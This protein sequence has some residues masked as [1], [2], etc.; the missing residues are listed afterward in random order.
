M[1]NN[2]SEKEYVNFFGQNEEDMIK[3]IKKV[4]VNVKDRLHLLEV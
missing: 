4:E 3:P 1:S 2:I